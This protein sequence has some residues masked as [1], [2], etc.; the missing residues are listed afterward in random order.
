MLEDSKEN[1]NRH[2]LSL[3]ECLP[4]HIYHMYYTRVNDY[5]RILKDELLS[6]TTSHLDKP[7]IQKRLEYL[8][9]EL[10]DLVGNEVFLDLFI[11]Y[12]RGECHYKTGEDLIKL[13]KLTYLK[14]ALFIRNKIGEFYKNIDKLPSKLQKEKWKI[15][16]VKRIPPIVAPIEITIDMR[17]AIIKRA[18][19]K[20]E[21]CRSSIFDSPIDVFQIKDAEKLKLVALCENCRRREK[22]RILSKP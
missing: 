5:I 13:I 8:I 7:L 12:K 14:Y 19:K 2:P 16:K 3:R 22:D 9:V 4:G 6:L 11:S 21:N 10:V 17:F 15:R 1:S 20:C 18:N